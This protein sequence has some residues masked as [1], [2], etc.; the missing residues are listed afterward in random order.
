MAS[1][2][3]VAALS[4]FGFFWGILTAAVCMVAVAIGCELFVLR[5]LAGRSL[6]LVIMA[7]LGLSVMGQS[8]IAMIW[9]VEAQGST[10]GPMGRGVLEIGGVSLPWASLSII[11][12]S[13]VLLAALW[14]FFQRTR[15]G[16]ALRATADHHEAAMAQGISMRRVQL[17]SWGIAGLLAVV[18]GV[19]L[20]AFPRRVSP[21]MVDTA[22]GVLP[23]LVIGGFASLVGAVVGGVSVGLM[24]VLGAGYLTS[25]GGGG[26]YVVLPYVAMLVVL[27]VRPSGLFGRADVE[28]V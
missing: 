21:S 4:P 22:L 23:A 10:E 25:F 1:A 12:V 7:T 11:A 17:V 5:R 8:A 3:I 27:A 26:L 16:L 9:G 6:Y 14:F 24:L 13:L 15:M 2:Y 28:R 19:F 20:G 18:A